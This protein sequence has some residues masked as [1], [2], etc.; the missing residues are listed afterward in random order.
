MLFNNNIII[1]I[2]AAQLSGERNP[3]KK[4]P[5]SAEFYIKIFLALRVIKLYA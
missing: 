1:L 2:I 3:A 4:L 5:D